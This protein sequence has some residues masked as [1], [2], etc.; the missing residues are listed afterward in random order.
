[1]AIAIV[2]AACLVSLTL[3]LTNNE[4]KSTE[5][6]TATAATSDAGL[7]VDDLTRAQDRAAQSDLRNVLVAA[8]TSY[9]GADSYANATPSQLSAIEPS[10]CYV[11]SATTSFASDASCSG[12]ASISVFASTDGWA[13]ARM[14]DSGTCFWIRDDPNVGAAYGSGL[15]CTGNAAT[16]AILSTW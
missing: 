7:N 13:A 4:S 6:D 1:M 11:D 9:T 10:L 12:Q 2:G 14:S 3:I 15:P 5:P 16:S 8:K